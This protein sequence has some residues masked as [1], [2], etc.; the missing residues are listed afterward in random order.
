MSLYEISRRLS[1]SLP[2]GFIRISLSLFL[3]NFH[4]NTSFAEE[5]SQQVKIVEPYIELHTGPGRGFPI[6]HIE[7]RGQWI[8]LIKRKTD[9]Y[10]I[11]TNAN[12]QGWVKR[13]QLELTVTEAGHTKT[14]RDVLVD[15]YLKRRLELGVA[16][17]K[18]KGETTQS[19]RVDYQLSPY[20]AT[21]LSI[22]Q[23]S[24]SFTTS[25]IYSL[26]LLSQPFP[27][28]R[29]SPFFN[30]GIGR[31]KDVPRSTLVDAKT[32]DSTTAIAGA[33]TRIY[34]TRRFLMRFDYRMYVILIDD[35][36]TKE[37]SEF[38]GGLS[39]FF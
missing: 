12:K 30:L 19:I 10:L 11:N 5:N 1:L 33:G 4:I 26:H 35:D 18:M 22:T 20:F 6:F 37:M 15:D 29:I 2:Y 36:R 28:W 8:T 7:K 14:F 31:F 25:E 38:S 13:S 34:I 21:E 32:T 23:V 16:G 27:K 39:F 9:W 17:G 3:I 24:G